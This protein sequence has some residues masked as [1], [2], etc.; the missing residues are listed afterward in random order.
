[1]PTGYWLQAL[2]LVPRSKLAQSYSRT[3]GC[4]LPYPC[5][6]HGQIQEAAFS[7]TVTRIWTS[8]GDC[9]IVN[10]GIF[11]HDAGYRPDAWL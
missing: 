8:T 6:Y 4:N 9:R 7:A 3:S 5:F 1:M 11:L 2:R 10:I